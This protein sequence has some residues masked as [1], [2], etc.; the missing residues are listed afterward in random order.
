MRRNINLSRRNK[1]WKLTKHRPPTVI[2]LHQHNEKQ[3]GDI[4]QKQYQE[5]ARIKRQLHMGKIHT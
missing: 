1:K 2:N 4:Q 5:K 3:T